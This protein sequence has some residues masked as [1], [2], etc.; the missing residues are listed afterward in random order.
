[1]TTEKKGQR[2]IMSDRG[3]LNDEVKGY[4][5]RYHDRMTAEQMAE[6]LGQP[7]RAGAIQRYINITF[8]DNRKIKKELKLSQELETRP[9]WQHFREQFTPKELDHFRNRYVQLMSQFRDDIMPTEEMQIFQVITIDI[10][11]QRTMREQK[12]VNEDLMRAHNDIESLMDEFNSS[13]KRALLE[14]VKH[15]EARYAKCADALK[16]LSQRYE[17]YL[18]RQS[19]MLKELKATRDQRVKIFENS[20]QSFLG[21]LRLLAEE[22]QQVVKGREAEMMRI[23]SDEEARRLAEPIRYDDGMI[24]QPLLTP[25]TVKDY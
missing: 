20:R 21:Y 14:E 3:P 4:I 25:E 15:C 7:K 23:A 9:E 6:S 5:D 18:M 11:I 13:K 1:M 12:E 10:L 17:A 16:N 22:D 2:P 8:G 19:A 24:D